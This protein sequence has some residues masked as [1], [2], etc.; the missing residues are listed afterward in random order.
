MLNFKN[1]FS[2]LFLIFFLNFGSVLILFRW[3]MNKKGEILGNKKMNLEKKN[4]K[5]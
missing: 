3:K 1:A 5:F 4:P 2:F